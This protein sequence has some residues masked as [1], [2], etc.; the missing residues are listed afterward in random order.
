MKGQ[1]TS[2][3]SPKRNVPNCQHSASEH[4]W[5]RPGTLETRVTV[6][7]PLAL[8]GPPHG[9]LPESSSP[10][11]SLSSQLPLPCATM[12]FTFSFTIIHIKFVFS[13]VFMGKMCVTDPFGD[14]HYGSLTA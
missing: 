12:V 13:S 10:A 14:L 5:K 3:D 4:S 11:G 9:D 6:Q 2:R 8:V 7:G 1:G